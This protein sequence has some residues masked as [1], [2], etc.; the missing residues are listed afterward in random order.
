[1]IATTEMTVERMTRRRYMEDMT[2]HRTRL[3]L[4]LAL[5]FGTAGHAAAAASAWSET[6]GGGVRLVVLP[7]S[8][9]GTMR[10]MLDIRLEAGWKTYWRDPGESGIPPSIS[11]AEGGVSMT[12]IGYPVPEHFDDG[13][14]RYTGYDQS[15][16][17]PIT[18]KAEPG[19]RKAVTASVFLGVCR[20]ICI[21][22]QADLTAD[23]SRRTFVNP[24]EETAVAKAEASLPGPARAGFRPLAASWSEDG[25]SLKVSFEAPADENAT[26]EVFLSGADGLQFGVAKTESARHGIFRVEVPLVYKPK[27]TDLAKAAILLTVRS[28]GETMESPLVVD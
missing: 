22:L 11:F 17:L 28:G 19:A 27:S 14:T 8:P 26:P 9:D 18:L 7:P 25:R 21:P 24:L 23:V 13:T 1:M 16:A 5:V 4:V 3:L 15:V 20:D 12:A 6:E 10:A 2:M